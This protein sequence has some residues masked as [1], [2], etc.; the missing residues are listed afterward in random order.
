[1]YILYLIYAYPAL[2]FRT[3]QLKILETETI[4]NIN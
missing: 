3:K 4:V 1:M 2:L